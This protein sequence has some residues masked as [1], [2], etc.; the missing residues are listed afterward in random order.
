ML[1]RGARSRASA[2][3]PLSLRGGEHT[4][5]SLATS[6]FVKE[7]FRDGRRECG[8][9]VSSVGRLAPPNGAQ[10]VASVLLKALSSRKQFKLIRL[11]K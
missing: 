5:P 10:P 3:H 8:L 1:A 9:K 4:Q 2:V 11:T 6:S 7:V